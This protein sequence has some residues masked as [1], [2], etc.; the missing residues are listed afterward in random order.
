MNFYKIAAVIILLTKPVCK[1]DAF[2]AL[3]QPKSIFPATSLCRMRLSIGGK[4]PI[5][6]QTIIMNKIEN[7]K[8]VFEIA[9]CKL[10]IAFSFIHKRAK[11]LLAGQHPGHE[12]SIIFSCASIKNNA[13]SDPIARIQ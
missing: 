7:S 4:F 8:L 13:R 3:S 9:L 2:P 11:I 10:G 1:C 5:S 12:C 6:Q